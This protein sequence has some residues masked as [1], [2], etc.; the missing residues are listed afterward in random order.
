MNH[1][2]KSNSRKIIS[3]IFKV[4]AFANES[5]RRAASAIFRATAR[6]NNEINIVDLLEALEDVGI[7]S[8]NNS[9]SNSNNLKPEFD[10]SE[11]TRGVPIPSG[12]ESDTESMSTTCS[13]VDS[14]V[15]PLIA[16]SPEMPDED[17][18]N[19]VIKCG[20]SKVLSIITMEE[21]REHDTSNDG[22]MILYDKVYNFT[23]FLFQVC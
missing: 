15:F 5:L 12:S 3:N 17:E 16:N 10:S 11:T 18:D 22:W 19:D 14:H 20:S 6:I 1:E 4:Y 23:D 8:S 7:N 2:Q 9:N 21:V 13:S